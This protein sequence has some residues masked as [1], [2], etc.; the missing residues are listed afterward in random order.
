MCALRICTSWQLAFVQDHLK[1]KLFQINTS[2]EFD[3]MEIYPKIMNMRQA[4]NQKYL[5]FEI[6]STFVDSYD[7]MLLFKVMEIN[8][9]VM[10]RAG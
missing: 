7:V 6:D 10:F 8:V 3:H 9:N 4:I 2:Y 1:A 5:T